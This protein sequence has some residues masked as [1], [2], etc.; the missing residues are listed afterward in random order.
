MFKSW[1]NCWLYQKWVHH[2]RRIVA[3]SFVSICRWKSGTFASWV[4]QVVAALWRRCRGCYHMSVACRVCWVTNRGDIRFIVVV[5]FDQTCAGKIWWTLLLV[6]YLESHF[7]II[8]WMSGFLLNQ[9]DISCWNR[10]S[11]ECCLRF[12]KSSW[13]VHLIF[14]LF[15][16]SCLSVW[17]GLVWFTQCITVFLVHFKYLSNCL[18]IQSL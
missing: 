10:P 4:N 2:C 12:I 7:A 8:F 3:S 14:W 5:F 9:R 17:V 16:L 6:V 1:D 11:K 18:L 15:V 13:K